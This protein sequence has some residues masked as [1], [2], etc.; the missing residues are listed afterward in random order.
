MPHA[1]YAK[2]CPAC[3]EVESE[4]AHSRFPAEFHDND[5]PPDDSAGRKRTRLALELDGYRRYWA[6]VFPA[7]TILDKKGQER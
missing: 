1:C 7:T 4:P 5:S 6:R 3:L 2:P